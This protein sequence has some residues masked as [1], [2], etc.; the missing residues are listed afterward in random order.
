MLEY[1]G[2]MINTDNPRHARLRRIVSAAFNPRMIKSIEEHIELVAAI[3]H[4]PG[5]RASVGATSWSR[6][7]P[8]S[9]SRSS[10]T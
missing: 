9:R 5:G 10:A 6:W 2:S 8:G 3:G 7:R 4:R 1:F